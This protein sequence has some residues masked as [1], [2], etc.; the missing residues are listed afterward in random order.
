MNTTT[1][2]LLRSDEFTCPSCVGKIERALGK[3]SGVSDATVA[4]NTGRID[5]DH[6]DT[7]NVDE[8]VEVVRR[9][10]YAARPAAF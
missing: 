1:H 10:G 8:L 6:D 9:V 5:I 2:T 7:T 3:V 4:F